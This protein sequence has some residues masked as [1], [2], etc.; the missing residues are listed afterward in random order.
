MT[1]SIPVPSRGQPLKASWGAALSSRVNELCAMA[2]AGMLARDGL[3][4]MGAQPLPQ[5]RRERQR[6]YAKPLPWLCRAAAD[7]EGAPYFIVYLPAGSLVCDL[8]PV[9]SAAIEGITPEPDADDWYR[10]SADVAAGSDATLELVVTKE[11]PPEGEEGDPTLVFALEATPSGEDEGDEG[12]DDG[13]ELGRVAFAVVGVDAGQDDAPDV[14]SV[15][16]QLESGV[17]LVDTARVS[18]DVR[19][20]GQT[21]GI[22]Q[23]SHFHDDEKDSTLGI[24]KRLKADPET[25]KISAEEDS[26]L[27]LLARK[28]GQIIYVPLDG[29]GEDPEPPEDEAKDPCD[30]D[31]GG[32]KAGGVSADA[33]EEEGPHGGDPA[34]AGGAGGVSPGSATDSHTGDD[35]CNCN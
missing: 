9:S 17:M 26:G 28:D 7:E 1:G 22:L 32:G 8:S 27:M 5:N 15:R 14:G 13:E 12:D 29:D 30:H 34:V 3:T 18:V 2:P 10:I 4:G 6:A 21:K 16:R 20:V 19:S 23:V 31:K 24:A 11:Y 25:G 33:D 35:D